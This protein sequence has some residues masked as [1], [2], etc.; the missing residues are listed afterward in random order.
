MENL[1]NNPE[2][3]EIFENNDEISGSFGTPW[4]WFGCDEDA[5]VIYHLLCV[6]IYKLYILI[7]PHEL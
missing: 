2:N 6:I 4:F 7:G 3:D 1:E 5:L